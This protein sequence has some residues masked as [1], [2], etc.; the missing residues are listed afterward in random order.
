MSIW[1][2]LWAI[3]SVGLLYFTVWTM[4]V[5]HKQKKSWKAFAKK[6]KL[7]YQANSMLESPEVKGVLDDY[8]VGVFMGE[9]MSPD[10]RRARKLTAIEVNLNS[11]M[12]TEGAIASADMVAVIQE[13]NFKNEIK[14]DHPDWKISYVAASDNKT[15]LESY[16]TKERQEVLTGLMKIKNAAVIFIFRGEVA[17]LRFD[18]PEPLDSPKKLDQ[19]VKKMIAA[20]RILEFN[21]ALPESKVRSES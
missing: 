3:L 10:M 5:L 13:L 16:L 2:V 12:P 14:P 21:D 19:L 18:T 17:L 8:T 7:R 4:F 15:V 11:I 1:F 9:H 20:A 6:Y